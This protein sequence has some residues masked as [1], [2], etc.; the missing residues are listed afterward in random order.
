MPR[1]RPRLPPGAAQGAGDPVLRRRAG[2][3]PGRQ[4]RPSRS[5]PPCVTSCTGLGHRPFQRLARATGDGDDPVALRR[6][7]AHDAEA[8]DLGAIDALPDL[9]RRLR[10]DLGPLH[11]LVNNAGLGSPG[12]RATATTRSPCAARVRTMPRPRPRLPP[13][14]T[15]LRMGDGRAR[16]RRDP[17][18]RRRSRRDRRAARPRPPPAPRPRPASRLLGEHD[19]RQ[20]VDPDQCLDLVVGHRRQQTLGAEAG[21]VARSASSPPISARSTRCPTSPAA[22][23]ATSAR[24]TVS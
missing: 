10:R 23:A 17:L 22:C 3:D 1:P 18:R 8:A 12:R 6:E 21:I 4:A 7:G 24:F 20:G 11:G 16:C 2:R 9:A 13:V 19:R 15:T 14:T 5:L